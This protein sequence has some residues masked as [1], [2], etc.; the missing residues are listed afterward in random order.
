M[1]KKYSNLS[2]NA[3]VC[4]Y[5]ASGILDVIMGV[6]AVIVWQLCFPE[7]RW[8]ML[9]AVVILA[10]SL[11]DLLV[12]PYIRYR[13][14]QYCID[15]ECIDIKE[16]LFFVKRNIVPI[17]RLHKI[18]VLRGPLDSMLGLGKVSV[19]T[20]G[21]DVVIRFLEIEKADRIVET[22]KHRINQM[23]VADREKQ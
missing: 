13:R 8:A 23:A 11:F 15:E 21:G 14:Y 7:E 22:L 9:V 4:M 3:L 19:T 10:I 20:A 2:K 17:E 6:A 18:A 5:V 1:N 16:G 12:C